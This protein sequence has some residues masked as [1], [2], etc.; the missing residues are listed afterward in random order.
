MNKTSRGRLFVVSGPSGVGKGTL[1]KLVLPT[2]P[3]VLYSISVTTRPPRLG[4]VDGRDYFFVTDEQFKRM[5]EDG[6]FLEWA[7]VYGHMYGTPRKW[8]EEKLASGYDVVLEIDVQGAMQVKER[9][10]DAILILILPPSMEELQRR[11]TKRALD[12][13]E[14]I[15]RRM[16]KAKWEISFRDRFDFQI[17]N[18]DLN[19]AAGELRRIL[20]GE[21]K[22]SGRKKG[23]RCNNGANR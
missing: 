6:E 9:C 13:P 20:L 15:E 10:K 16:N 19:R 17:V 2:L 22:P 14:E 18:D 21:V 3:N 8:V 23:V 12:S 11:I 7:N 1:L 4:E 5:I